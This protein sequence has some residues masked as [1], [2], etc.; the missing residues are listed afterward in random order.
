[1]HLRDF[2]WPPGTPD[3]PHHSVVARYFRDYATHF[4]LRSS[5]AFETEV[6]SCEPIEPSGYLVRVRHLPTQEVREELFSDVI[7]ASGHHWS[8]AL[9]H[10]YPP[11]HFEGEVLHSHAYVDPK[12]PVDCSDRNV[13]VVGMGNSAVDIASELSRVGGAGRVFVSARRGVWVLPKYIRGRPLDGEPSIPTWIPGKL[14]RWLVTRSFS[15]LHG[16]MKDYGLPEPDHFIGEAH[17][18]ISTEFPA[19]VGAGDI[20]MR[21]GIERLDGREVLFTDGSRERIDVLLFSTGYRVEFPFFAE[22]HVLVQGNDLPLFRRVFHPTHRHVFFLGLAQPTGA[23]L[24]IAEAQASWIAEYLTGS[25]HLPHADD[26]TRDIEAEAHER[27]LRYVA[28]PRHTMQIDPHTY[29]THLKRELEAGR[30]RARR[31]LGR[32]SPTAARRLPR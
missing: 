21:P 14:R 23:I 16:R 26:V 19:L 4:G 9:P 22:S 3:F 31:G 12:T 17:P 13:L 30:R 24:P 5:I 11:G 6:L 7:V 15:L 1:M 10:P 18:T 8:P 32:R 29:L 2:P 20:S 27:E 25:Y 28:S